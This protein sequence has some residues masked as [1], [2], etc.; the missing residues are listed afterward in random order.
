MRFSPIKST[1]FIAILFASFFPSQGF[2]KEK[3][4]IEIKVEEEKEA[5]LDTT[6]HAQVILPGEWK[7]QAQTVPQLLEKGA[8]V[9]LKQY[10]GLDDFAAV[11]IRGSTT[12]QVLIYLDGV[13]LN[14]AHGGILDLSMIPLDQIERIEVY[15]GGAPGKMTDSAPGGVIVIQTKQKTDKTK[16]S[17]RNSYGSFTTYR[18]HIEHSQNLK[19]FYYNAAFD[20]HRSR[21]D[22]SF[23]D[24]R[25][26]RANTSDDRTRNRQN[27]D[28]QAYD[29]ATMIG[30][31]K[32]ESL[33]WKVYE[34]FFLK[35]AGI[36][37]FGARTSSQ[38]RLDTLKNIFYLAL[39]APIKSEKKLKWKTD[40]SFDYLNSQFQDRSGQIG[41]GTQDNNDDTFRF[42]PALHLTYLGIKNQI[43]SGFVAHRAE[44][45]L[46]T[47]N[48]ASPPNGPLSQR[49]MIGTGLEDEI[50]LLEDKIN[51]TPSIRHQTFLNHLSGQDPSFATQNQ[52]NNATDSQIS[53]KA[54]LKVSPWRFLSFKTNLTR[55][56][57]QPTFTE[58]FGDRGTILGNS[59]LLA[60]KSLNFDFGIELKQKKLGFLDSLHLSAAYFRN[61]IDNLIQFL[62]TSQF[63]IRAD[64]INSAQIL[65]GE[66]S[67]ALR[68]FKNFK[69]SAHYTYQTAKD[70]E[71]TSPTFGRFLPGRPKHQFFAEADYQFP[72]VRPF[73]EVQIMGNNYLDSQNLLRV[74]RRTLM[75]G[76]FH[77]N[78]LKWLEASF[79]VKN[80]FNDR[81]EDIVGYPLPGRSYW[82]EVEV[83]F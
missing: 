35:Q 43:L 37:G 11:S 12:E 52:D 59:V 77:T 16:N 56:F 17:L 25:G 26:T 34:N 1:V 21:G 44:F 41:L 79:S 42:G 57:R 38:A 62:Q 18:G 66:F 76:G 15:K 49:H 7:G 24:N 19:P 64:N 71:Q 50:S 83:E 46:P 39:E 69:G 9:Q 5:G 3:A 82:G 63:T 14:S 61:T 65:G 6:S 48:T 75:A 10:G 54:G 53:A 8:G 13:L 74:T 30:G 55:G 2:P 47:N 36:P 72:F 27:N 67:V 68:A 28:F 33:Q 58:L 40:L 78:P 81:I 60:E 29:F 31:N 73:V 80:I 20:H 45:F 22:F 4:Q 51:F 32:E 23:L 70:S